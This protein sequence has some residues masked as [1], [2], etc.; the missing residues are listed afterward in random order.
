[1]RVYFDR[2]NL[3]SFFASS[4]HELFA[5]CLR[6]LKSQCDLYLNFSKQALANPD[7]ATIL[8][9]FTSGSKSTEKPHFNEEPVPSRPI[10]SNAPNEFT[11]RD[12]FTAAYL[13]TDEKLEALKSK[14]SILLG[15][16]GEEVET[17]S[18]LFFD[19]Y[20]FTKPFT[21][22]EH[23][24]NWDA[25]KPTVL[26]CT[27]IIIVDRYLFA[28]HELLDYN[29]HYLLSTLG[30]PQEQRKYNIVIFTCQK[31]DASTNGRKEYITPDWKNVKDKIKSYLKSK[32][33]S[34]PNVTIVTLRRVKEHDRTIFSNYNNSY[35]GDSL[36]YYNSKWELITASR[37]YSVHSHGL[38]DNLQKGYFF[39]EDMQ[40]VIDEL[41][42]PRDSELIIGDKK[43]NFLNFPD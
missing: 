2:D 23:M 18:R 14:G 20:Q 32:N 15:G 17:L 9:Q 36:T 1:M 19:D 35:S 4:N 3:S 28:S 33:G 34:T 24:P 6:M 31:Q 41:S 38:R 22:K 25:L 21:P 29:I 10:K 16:K 30:G 7:I 39:I 42:L 12:Q 13:L 37:N 5:D 26:P 11:C 40:K 43:C 8:S 27:D